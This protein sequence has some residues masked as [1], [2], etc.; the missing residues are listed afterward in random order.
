VAILKITLAAG[1]AG[2][3]PWRAA[4]AQAGAAQSQPATQATT[5]PAAPRPAVA[6]VPGDL[7]A[8]EQQL[9]RPDTPPPDR[10]EA[11]A[12]L[13]SR[14]SAEADERLRNILVST[15]APR[16]A[17]LAVARALADDPSPS[18]AM[19]GPLAE[20][21]RT[22][23]PRL[24]VL[25]DA[26]AQ[27]LANYRR[28]ATAVDELLRFVADP[29]LPA[30]ARARVVR[31]LGRVVEPA[32]AE[33]LV[34]LQSD[35]RE[36][37]RAAAA[38]ALAEL[39]GLRDVG[40]DA[41]RWQQWWQRNADVAGLNPDR[42][43]AEL[44]EAKAANL[45]RLRR[46]HD[47][48]TEALDARMFQQYQAAPR[49]QRADLLL[50]FLKSD[51]PDERAIAARLVTRA[52]RNQDVIS[53]K[54]RERLVALVGDSDPAVRYEVAIT[55]TNL[56][57]RAALGAELTQLAQERE[58]RVKV[59]LIEALARI[60][61]PAAAPQLVAALVGDGS[62]R[63]F[64]A[65]AAA[66]ARVGR[67]LRRANAPLADQA[68]RRLKAVAQNRMAPAASRTAA[69][70]ALAVL[71]APDLVE[72]LQRLLAGGQGESTA[73]RQAA[74]R[75]LGALGGQGAA[76]IITAILR[77]PDARDPAMRW[78]A[79]DALGRAGNLAEHGGLLLDYTQRNNE[80]EESVRQKAWEAYQALLPR[81]SAA[82][83][84]REL[85]ALRTD[86][87]RQAVVLEELC[88]KLEQAPGP[89]ARDD[90]ANFRVRLGEVYMNQNPPQ[91]D[92]AIPR[93]RQA[94]DHYLQNKAAEAVTEPLV[95]QL[96]D[97]YLKSKD[98]AQTATFAEQMIAHDPRQKDTVGSA[99]KQEADRL[100]AAGDTRSALQLID[101]GLKMDPQLDPR[102]R[103]D[104][105]LIR[106]EIEAGQ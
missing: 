77:G 64:T 38:D 71:Q 58:E 37:L 84:T 23:D 9:F 26:A 104:L 28:N 14:Q 65:A 82:A 43:R 94:L 74:L 80:P 92:K 49:D 8:L 101:E 61:D 16:D 4:L 51:Q 69:L 106:Q 17:R 7:A 31:V 11:A 105:Q 45:E 85:Q 29:A 66:L 34:A 91:S 20:L 55:L 73:V 68:V 76:E 59:A 36:N 25:V 48:L 3:V 46:R 19:V 79:L 78:W 35:P 100:R 96:M 93:F 50:A 95:R 22:P 97:A 72:F 42:W 1:L 39:T 41:A 44:L 99:I 81:A 24:L 5:A 54:V 98:Y 56:N 18:E 27:A 6:D 47:A 10:E 90:L 53:E 52:F 67:D 13:I 62:P 86:P 40:Q 30:D 2:A 102:H 32:V 87:V 83:L 12:R 70:D 57:H 15:D 60:E 75:A 103:D 63:V 21:M 33:R 89:Q 88:R